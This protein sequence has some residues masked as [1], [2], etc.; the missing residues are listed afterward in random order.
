MLC[1]RPT[2]PWAGRPV[3]ELLIA[4]L[5]YVKD[6]VIPPFKPFFRQP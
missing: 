2:E 3:D 1:L 6:R 4:C 5:S